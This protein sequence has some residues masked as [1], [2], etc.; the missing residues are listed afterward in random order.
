[1]AL[2]FMD[3]I[4][5]YIPTIKSPAKPLSLKEKMM[6]TGIILSVYFVL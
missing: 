2:E 1:M 6:W 5:K 3:K 4:A